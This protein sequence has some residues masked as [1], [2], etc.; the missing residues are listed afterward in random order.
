MRLI[1]GG[2]KRKTCRESTL[3]GDLADRGLVGGMMAQTEYLQFFGGSIR[4]TPENQ[5]VVHWFRV[6]W[7]PGKQMCG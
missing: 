3:V 7:V 2:V 5:R 1:R 4:K 6:V